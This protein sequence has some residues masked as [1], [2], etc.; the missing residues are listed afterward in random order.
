MSWL[1]RVYAALL[2][3]AERPHCFRA[4]FGDE[5]QRVFADAVNNATYHV[6]T[7]RGV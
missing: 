5:M 2:R 7:Q 4:E 6:N 1:I 3:S